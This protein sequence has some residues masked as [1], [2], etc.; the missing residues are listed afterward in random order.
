MVRVVSF[1]RRLPSLT[2]EEFFD[3][4]V[5]HGQIMAEAR[6]MMGVVRYHQVHVTHHELTQG[7]N[8]GRGSGGTAAYDGVAELWLDDISRLTGPHSP[9]KLDFLQRL[10]AH[11]NTF[12]D[13]PRSYHVVGDEHVIVPV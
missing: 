12:V 9:E 11:E 5:E 1:L 4:W 3:R 13:H 2:Q 8:D 6:E 10:E 7:F